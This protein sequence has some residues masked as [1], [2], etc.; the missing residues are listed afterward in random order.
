M[1]LKRKESNSD[2]EYRYDNNDDD[3]LNDDAYEDDD[4]NVYGE[5]DTL[6]PWITPAPP[7]MRTPTMPT[8]PT[9]PSPPFEGAFTALDCGEDKSGTDGE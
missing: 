2:S 8:M 5:D 4:K 1:I 9:M 7:T 3:D 6:P